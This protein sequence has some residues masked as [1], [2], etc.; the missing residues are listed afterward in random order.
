[1]TSSDKEQVFKET[2]PCPYRK[3]SCAAT[4]R[5]RAVGK[6][7]KKAFQIE[8]EMSAA[9]KPL[10]NVHSVASGSPGRLSELQ[11]DDVSAGALPQTPVQKSSEET[12][13]WGQRARRI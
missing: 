10:R 11:R 1:M 12:R 6:Q 5:R 8:L 4:L 3:L 9:R 2:H 13:D 7:E